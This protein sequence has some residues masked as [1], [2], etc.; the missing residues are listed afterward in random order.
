[1]SA[2]F[3]SARICPCCGNDMGS[4]EQ[5]VCWTCW[6]A[7]NKLDVGTFD[8]PG[9][10]FG[11]FSVSAEDVAL[12]NAERDVRIARAR[13]NAARASRGLAVLR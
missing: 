10:R 8:D 5:V 9:S 6:H 7:S 13:W 3:A 2:G 4:P 1:M 11:V 12:W